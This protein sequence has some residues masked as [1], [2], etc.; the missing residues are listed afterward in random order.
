MPKHGDPPSRKEIETVRALRRHG[1]VPGAARELF[2]TV[3]T[4]KTHLRHLATKTGEHQ[5][6]QIVGRAYEEGWMDPSL[7]LSQFNG[8]QRGVR[9]ALAGAES[10]PTLRQPDAGGDA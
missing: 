2:V 4:V 5:L 10:T 7:D 9:R 3:N 6:P 8:H 1:S